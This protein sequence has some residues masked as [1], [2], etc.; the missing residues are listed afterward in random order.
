MA[1]R[2]FK[3]HLLDAI[4]PVL[5]WNDHKNNPR[6][7][8]TAVLL[9]PCLAVTALHVVEDF[10]PARCDLRGNVNAAIVQAST[11]AAWFIVRSWATTHT[12][13]ALL[14]LKPQNEVAKKYN[15]H[16]FGI[17]LHL[18]KPG[19]KVLIAGFP[20]SRVDDVD[21]GLTEKG[22][23]KVKTTLNLRKITGIVQESQGSRRDSK[24]GPW[25]Q[26]NA[27]FDSQMSGGPVMDA[28]GYLRGLVC[29]GWDF[30]SS[31]TGDPVSFAAGILP[32]MAIKVDS[33]FPDLNPVEP[34][35]VL[36]LA[37]NGFL[38]VVDHD[39]AKIVDLGSGKTRMEFK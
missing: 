16:H 13:A 9:G 35:H 32:I 1:E 34:Y 30:G 14:A 15:W 6:V 38:A 7:V 10:L 20:E 37:K 23:T 17:N 22:V 2:A 18:P 4:S 39:R 25:F 24:L 27:K 11:G 33:T 31:D 29:T 19:A 12:D 5:V 3:P 26:C 8:G 36:E 28:D 21:E